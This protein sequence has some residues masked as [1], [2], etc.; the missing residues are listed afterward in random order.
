MSERGRRLLAPLAIAALVAGACAP[1]HSAKPTATPAP[2]ASPTP[3]TSRTVVV[4]WFV[5]L[6][7][8]NDPAQIVA[9][10]AFVANYNASQS[11]I[12]IDLEVVPGATAYDTLKAEIANGTGP[13][14]IGPIGVGGR[15]GL[16]GLFLDLKD[17]AIRA[18]VDMT[19]YPE[20]VVDM[21]KD[22]NGH[23]LGLPYLISPAFI[24]YNKDIFAKA[25]LP[26][27]PKRVG[28]QWNGKPWSWDTLATIA[29]QLTLDAKKRKPT[30]ALFDPTRIV[31]YGVDFQWSDLPRTASCFASG[32]LVNSTTGAAVVPDAWQAGLS[33]YYNAMWKTHSAPTAKVVNS[34]ALAMGST[35]ASGKVAMAVSWPWAISTYAGSPAPNGT[36]KPRFANWDIA[37]IPA[38]NGTTT[39]P[40]DED[41]L[42]ISKTSAHPDQAFQAMLAIVADPSLQVLYGGMPA[43]K[44]EQQNWFT[45]FD[46]YLEKLFPGNKISWTV[47][48]EMENF[49]AVPS[50][51]VDLPNFPKVNNITSSFYSRLQSVQGLTLPTE[52][53]NLQAQLQRAFDQAYTTV[54]P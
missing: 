11:K 5:G 31:Q 37:V 24:F 51:E 16:A 35:V 27:L 15:N 43:V 20:G 21:L 38:Y 23:L 41:S 4:R 10:K 42:S 12:Y 50:P 53:A 54:Q 34:P 46:A 13:D 9:E 32:S 29:T 3:V 1:S 18:N 45:Q 7:K 40:T 6:G 26:P 48:Q 17:E 30:D 44:D 28:D 22:G 39:S 19:R 49:P 25:N 47:L 2:T 52:F 36:Y 8:G 14:I 33:W